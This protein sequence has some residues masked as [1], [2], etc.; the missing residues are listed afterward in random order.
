VNTDYRLSVICNTRIRP[1]ETIRV[2]YRDYTA[3]GCYVS[4]DED[5]YIVGVTTRVDAKGL[6]TYDLEVST[7]DKARETEAQVL[8]RA[9]KSTSYL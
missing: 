8:A 5:L 6:L 9:V 2:V 3:D 1:G 7:I 4:I